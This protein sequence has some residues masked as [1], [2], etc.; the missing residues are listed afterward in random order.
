MRS[1]ERGVPSA[2]T[3]ETPAGQAASTGQ[4]MSAKPSGFF[5]AHTAVPASH[6]RRNGAESHA[7][8]SDSGTP[9]GIS[10]HFGRAFALALLRI[11]AALGILAGATIGAYHL[12]HLGSPLATTGAVAVILAAAMIVALVIPVGRRS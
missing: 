3:E 7:P 5:H 8:A 1:H 4:V 11:V 10:P 9:K 12:S 2:D 6:S